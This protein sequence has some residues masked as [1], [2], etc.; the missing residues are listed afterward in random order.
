MLRAG[1]FIKVNG[2]TIDAVVSLGKYPRTQPAVFHKGKLK[3]ALGYA[4]GESIYAFLVNIFSISRCVNNSC[5]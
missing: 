4:V 5:N 1:I 2:V 3:L